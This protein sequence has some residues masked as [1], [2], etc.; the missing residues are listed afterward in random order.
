MEITPII[1]HLQVR[2]LGR[3]ERQ[4]DRLQIDGV[5]LVDAAFDGLGEFDQ[6]FFLVFF[7]VFPNAPRLFFFHQSHLVYRIRK[8]LMRLHNLDELWPLSHVQFL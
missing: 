5:V 2:V 4:Y 7:E 1:S 8:L 6:K 3:F